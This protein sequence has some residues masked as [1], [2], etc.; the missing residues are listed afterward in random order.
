MKQAI[1]RCLADE[2]KASIHFGT[3]GGHR[4]STSGTGDEE[5]AITGRRY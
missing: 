4:A 2:D 3:F 5:G 1:G